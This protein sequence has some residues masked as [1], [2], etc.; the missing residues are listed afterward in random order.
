MSF[1]LS[2]T[3]EYSHRKYMTFFYHVEISFW[4]VLHHCWFEFKVLVNKNTL[5]SCFTQMLT[6]LTLQLFYVHWLT[7]QISPHNDDMSLLGCQIFLLLLYQAYATWDLPSCPRSHLS[8]STR[9]LIKHCVGLTHFSC[10]F[11]LERKGGGRNWTVN[12]RPLGVAY[13]LCS[14]RWVMGHKLARYLEWQR[15]FCF[16]RSWGRETYLKMTDVGGW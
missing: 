12:G 4:S 6:S 3:E 16:P 13:K 11:S 7:K 8:R 15:M 1:W 10:R 9:W 5:H 14:G 2:S